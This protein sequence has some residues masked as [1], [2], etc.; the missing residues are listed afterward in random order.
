MHLLLSAALKYRKAYSLLGFS[1]LAMIALTIAS[2]LEIIAMAMLMQKGADFFTLFSTQGSPVLEV[3]LDQVQALWPEIS[4]NGHVITKA[5]AAKY[6][7]GHSQGGNFVFK[8][9]GFLSQYY[10]FADDL[11]KLSYFLLIIALI[12][13]VSSFFQGYTTSLVS[14]QVSRQLR[15]AYFSHVQTLP[16]SFF[17]TK[18]VSALALRVTSDASIVADAINSLLIN[19][20]QT[21]LVII[22]S[23][24][25]LYLVSPSLTM[26][27]FLGLPLIIFPAIFFTKKI[28][29]IT[30]NIQTGQEGASSILYDF[31]AGVQTIKVFTM[32]AF[33]VD[34]YGREN[35]HMVRMQERSTRYSLALRPILHFISTLML[36]VVIMYGFWIAN[37]QISDIV[38]FCAVLHTFYEPIKTFADQNMQIQRGVVAAERLFEVMQIEPDI[39]DAPDAKPM[40]PFRD[41]VEF[42]NVSFR[43]EDAWVLKNLDFTVNKG[44]FVALVGATGAGKSTI[45]QL[46]PRLY[47]V[48]EGEILIDGININKLTQLS[49]R[50]NISFVPQK[51]F[52]FLDTVAANISYGRPLSR[53]KVIEAAKLA[54]AHEFIEKL[55][56][57]YDTVLSETGKNLSGGQ[58][59]RLA[60]ARA[61]AKEAPILILDEATSS[62]DAVT[63]DKIKLALNDLRGRYTQ[64]VIAHRLS[65]IEKADRIIFMDH[66]KKLA[67]GNK[68][69]LLKICPSFKAMWDLMMKEQKDEP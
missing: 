8:V 28:K 44:E 22:T 47:D 63:E 60:I 18:N 21:P 49:L 33:A 3:S 13:G 2:K 69:E 41:K 5:D 45:A 62:L 9:I 29:G 58:Q 56:R 24:V 46:L 66:G 39:K 38:A 48:N 34:R 10:S 30:Q 26:L 19:Y 23:M 50:D 42:K 52:L 27:V 53:E 57:G 36:A 61:L 37:L 15:E 68:D 25:M 35:E 65:T 51:P 67:E 11:V 7:G 64:I 32:E 43:Y 59:Q 16:M 55:P 17:H 54:R 1:V 6:L 4:E 31:F 12:K 20:F 14:I 40:R